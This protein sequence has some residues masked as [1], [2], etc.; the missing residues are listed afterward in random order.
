VRVRT[1]GMSYGPHAI[2]HADGKVIFV[3]GGAPEEEADVVIREQRPRYAFADLAQVHVPSAARRTPPCPYLP[4]CGGCPWQH[5]EYEAQLAA[6]Q[7]AVQ[8]QL[9]R[10]AGLDPP[11]EPIIA[12]PQQ[13]GYRHR[14]KLRVQDGRV[15]FL[16]AASHDVV[17]IEHCLLAMPA[18]DAAIGAADGLVQSLRTNVRRIEIVDRGE[19]RPQRG[20]EKVAVGTVP[21]VQRTDEVSAEG[22]GVVVIVGEAEGKW[23]RE[24]AAA[25]ER[26]LAAT[27]GVAG[28]VLTGRG[29]RRTWGDCSAVMHPDAELALTLRAGSFTQV[30]PAMNRRL[31][32]TVLDYAAVQA[33]TRV[34]DLY[35]GIGNFSIPCAQRGAVVHAVEQHSAAAEDGRN[36]ARRMGLSRCHFHAETARH[37]VDAFVADGAAFDVVLL[38]PPRSG[39]ADGVPGLL[40]LAA[41]RLVYVSCNPS[42]LARDLKLLAPRY[43][44]A[45]V[46]PLDMFPHSYHVETVVAAKLA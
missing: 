11:I 8:E 5:L 24:D 3:R 29:W 4:R 43:R 38:D 23:Q 27:A 44:I 21:T 17:P 6:K 2:G 37:A 16:H 40:R 12:S 20:A 30:N 25:C 33:G 9:R 15:G 36:N 45:A 22:D 7:A 10:I 34:L 46:Q 1:R 14:L 18:V 28:L 31:V 39:A 35:A 41:P 26:W 19:P 32:S 42:S 13:L